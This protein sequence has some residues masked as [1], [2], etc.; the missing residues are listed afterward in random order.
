MN[1]KEIIQEYYPSLTNSEKHIA[2]FLLQDKDNTIVSLT[3]SEA[4]SR[5]GFGE[6]TIVRFCRKINFKGFQ[7]LKFAIALDDAKAQDDTKAENYLD[8]IEQNMINVIHN[9]KALI[10][11]YELQRAVKLISETKHLYFY[12]V[13]SSGFIA[14]MAEER[15]MRI[16]K[17]S[18]SFKESHLQCAQSAIC[19]EGD[20]IV[21][22]SLSGST[23]D[24]HEA[25]QVAKDNGCKI[26]AI[27]NHIHSPISRLADC[28]LL[29]NGKESPI[30]GGTL[31]SMTSQM[32]VI[33]LLVTGYSNDHME[34]STAYKEKVAR[35]ISKK[36]D[37]F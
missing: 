32:Y 30:T 13:G 28:I 29:T 18:K 17:R 34:E 9:T 20:V 3:L 23:R 22:I 19:D 31:T 7:D 33:D 10:D 1:T 12:G 37:L 21:V 26:I 15:L 11:I 25:V 2:D 6:A 36:L 27:T 5:L 35:A 8:V 16:G 14:E 24:L 4:S